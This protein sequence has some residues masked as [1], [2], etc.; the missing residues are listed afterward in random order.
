MTE[1]EPTVFVVD[2]DSSLR[3]SLRR[4]FK[5]VA[6]PVATFPSAQAFLEARR[7]QAPGCLVLDVRL[8][9][10]SGLDL[11]ARLASSEAAMPIV[12]LTGYGNIPMTVRAMK[13]GAVEFLT[14]PFR[15]QEL[16]DAV[17]QALERDRI[18]RTERARIAI[19][20]RHYD[21]LTGRERE[22]MAGVIAGLRNKDIASAF[23]TREYTVKE[24]RGQVMIK[25]Q[26][27]SVA[28]LVRV[29]SLL[30]VEP[31]TSQASFRKVSAT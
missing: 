18:Q 14:K 30:G 19:L 13:A 9:D 24:Q 27:S 6:L 29:A 11:Q 17:R 15:P 12:F 25:M 28:E 1:A 10:S 23:G 21:E 2:D 20:R 3:E 22:V 31:L 26:V 8:P 7:A 16:V 4:L 5:S